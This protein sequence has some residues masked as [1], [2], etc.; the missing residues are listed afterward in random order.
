MEPTDKPE[1]TVTFSSNHPIWISLDDDDW[2]GA[3]FSNFLPRLKNC[4]VILQPGPFHSLDLINR[5]REV[6]ERNCKSVTLDYKT[7]EN[8]KKSLS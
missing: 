7:T 2:N 8:Q 1:E 3:T 5:M 6:L 4:H